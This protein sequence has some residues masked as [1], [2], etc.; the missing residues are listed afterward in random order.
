MQQQLQKAPLGT[1]PHFYFIYHIFGSRIRAYLCKLFFPQGFCYKED[2]HFDA[3]FLL[4]HLH[5]LTLHGQST[6]PG[7]GHWIRRGGVLQQKTKDKEKKINK[8]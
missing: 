1:K 7:D 4:S 8:H 6:V 2:L 3:Y 5:N